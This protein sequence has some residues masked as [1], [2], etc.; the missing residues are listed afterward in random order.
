MRK[1]SHRRRDT[2]SSSRARRFP[3]HATVR[4]RADDGPWRQGTS[5]NISRSG[6]LLHAREPLTPDTPVEFVVDLPPAVAGEP[7]ATMVCRGRV[8]RTLEP[9]DISDILLALAITSCR[10]GRLDGT[11]AEPY[12]E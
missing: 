1:P 4:Y 11:A 6:L 7:S 12:D 5:E 2:T 10:I 3:I 8:S 9:I